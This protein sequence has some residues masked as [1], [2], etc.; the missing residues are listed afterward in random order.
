MAFCETNR[1]SI[2]ESLGV[3]L[4]W[5]SQVQIERS[6]TVTRTVVTMNGPFCCATPYLFR[7][8]NVVA[9]EGQVDEESFAYEIF[10]FDCKG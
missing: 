8:F 7:L 6:F 10:F 4:S 9:T 5:S 3:F 2:V 1:P